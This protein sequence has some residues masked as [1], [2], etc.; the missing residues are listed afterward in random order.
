MRRAGPA[1]LVT[2]AAV[3]AVT[4]L[5]TLAAPPARAQ[6]GV[7]GGEGG[8]GHCTG[9]APVVCHFDVTPGT[10][11]VRVLLGGGA[12]AGS[13][14]VTAET[15]RAMLA[16]TPN[17]P[18]ETVRRS[19]TVD[20]RDPEGEPTGAIGTPGLDLTFGGAAPQLASVRVERVRTPQILLAG[21]S[22][23]CD[24]AAEPYT[25]W[26]QRLPQYLTDRVS[27][28]NYADSGEGSQSFRDNP[29]LFPA[30]RSRIHH[31]DLV[32]VQLAHNDKQTDRETYR[33]N[34]TAMIE[35]VRAEGGRPVLVTPIVRRWFNADGTLDNGTALLVN[36]LGV[37]LPAEMRTLAAEQNTPLVD[38]TALTRARVEEL[39]P[40]GSKA[41]YLYDEK[42][43]NTH[44]SVRGATEY[45]GLVLAELRTLGLLA[46]R[47]VR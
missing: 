42:R 44:T 38:L 46:P 5:S 25:G 12:V 37:D 16:E 19:F 47:A 13:T 39:G 9:T 41:L 8:L 27:V 21:D 18:G 45:A 32:L 17:A 20:V 7:P 34:L 11:R 43:D 15:R 30:L 10:Y 36:G 26:G 24:Q 3:A 1:L 35:E 33:A 31:G 23:V 40:E 4:A 29:A 6:G 22:T 28:A 14:S 2:C